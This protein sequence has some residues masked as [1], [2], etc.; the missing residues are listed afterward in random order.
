MNPSP[1]PAQ[2]QNDFAKKLRIHHEIRLTELSRSKIHTKFAQIS[3]KF[4]E[5]REN[6]HHW[7]AEAAIQ[8][9]H[10]TGGSALQA[11]SQLW[12]GEEEEGEREEEFS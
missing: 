8:R 2:I 7:T 12:I 1:N 6:L 10:A 3:S 5:I 9:E 11:W 4:S